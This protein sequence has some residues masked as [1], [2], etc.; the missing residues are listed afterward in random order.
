MSDFRTA[1]FAA[2]GAPGA[3]HMFDRPR[4]GRRSVLVT[5]GACGVADD[6]RRV[7]RGEGPANLSWPLT[8]G[9]EAAGV[10]T[11]LG[12]DLTV[13]SLGAPL[14][15]GAKVLVP[16]FAPCTRCSVC[17]H[18]PGL[19]ARCRHPS[20]LYGGWA[21]AA[22]TDFAAHPGARLYRVPDDMPLWLAILTAPFAT[23]MRGL[24]RAGEAG[25]FTPGA[26][27][28]IHGTGP[29]A[30]LSVAAAR[31][32]GA[33]RVI[34]ATG[35]EDTFARLCRQFGA[36][37]TIG[38]DTP[39]ERIEIV[40]ETEAG[41]GADLVLNHGAVAA[42]SLAMLR[43]GGVCVD[44][45]PGGTLPADLAA[46]DLTLIGS[47]AHAPTDLVAGLRLLYRARGSYPFLKMIVRHPLTPT[48]IAA[49]LAEVDLKPVL[50]PN[51]DIIG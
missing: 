49:A 7:L 25:G 9:Q 15:P 26:T 14:K 22:H 3:I 13:D 35:S 8:P 39:A 20:H 4:L 24:R 21:D 2:P 28:V 12:T 11:E 36:E 27:V 5:I 10:I 1:V 51:P 33:G 45:G 23:A 50:V 43:D 47:S 31:E 18:H 30:L 38:S 34:V 44:F 46:R 29:I 17:L 48:G 32:M 19:A 41:L 37:A 42:D 6:D 16:S 40:R